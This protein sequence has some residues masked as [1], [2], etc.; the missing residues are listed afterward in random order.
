M[1]DET[2]HDTSPGNAPPADARHA[3][4][5]AHPAISQERGEDPAAGTIDNPIAPGEAQAGDLSELGA[6]LGGP[7]DVFPLRGRA[8]RERPAG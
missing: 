5:R 2:T 6:N 1:S 3:T 7:V 4:E 8:R